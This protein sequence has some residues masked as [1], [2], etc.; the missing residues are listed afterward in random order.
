[1]NYN[2]TI[3]FLFC[4]LPAFERQ[5]GA[6]YKPGLQ[7]SQDLDD[8]VGNPHRS[9][10]CI[11]VAGTNGKGSTSHL[12]ASILQE[13]GYK[14]GLYT[15]PHIVDFRERIRVN[16]EKISKEAV[17]DFT[18]RFLKLGYH[19]HPSFFEL[20]STMAFEYFKMQNVDI[21]II[22]VGL[23]G[24]LDSTNIIT[25]IL[26]IITNISI[27]H[28]QFLGSTP[29]QI[30]SEKAGI[31]KRGV[32]VV[33]GEAEGEV[34]TTF[35]NKAK[36][37]NVPI[38]FATDCSTILNA[39]CENGHCHINS[40]PYGTLINELGGEYQIKNSA[41]VLTALQALKDGGI[42]ISDDAVKAG[43]A[44]VIENTG[45]IGRWQTISTNPRIICDSG[46][47]VGAFTQITHQ[48][49]N[50]NYDTLHMV[51]G[52]MA[53]KDVD[54]VLAMLPK[55]A[56]YYFTQ[57]ASPRAMT[58]DELLQKAASHGLH[59]KSYP[60]VEEA[61]SA[62]ITAATTTD[63]IYIGGSMYILAEALKTDLD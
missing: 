26:S 4:Q 44:H 56:I 12:L 50:E 8:M 53:D 32:P 16:G 45:L 59:G 3:N 5:G 11:H 49:Q 22:E 31:I 48:L 30:A 1:M 21:A 14:V 54:H 23:G 63:L 18:E 19:G 15:S 42:Q 47:N 17:V 51:M 29:A 10:K 60:T 58:A 52:V 37:E 39:H 62:A 41:T 61:K 25:P 57:A 7:T 33:I 40:R 13:Q 20:T 55:D 6:G 46:H 34:R 43:F 24:R 27:D 35:K 2:D 9:Y 36:A 38:T 28:T